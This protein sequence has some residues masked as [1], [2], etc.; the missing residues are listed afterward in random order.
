MMASQQQQQTPEGAPPAPE[1]KDMPP[2]HLQRRSPHHV[3]YSAL[4]SIVSVRIA[5]LDAASPS[6]RSHQDFMPLEKEFSH[7][8]PRAMKDLYGTFRENIACP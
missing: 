7:S 3:D 6:L 4:S 2:D 1:H 5:L 8:W